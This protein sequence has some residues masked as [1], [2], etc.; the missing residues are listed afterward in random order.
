MPTPRCAGA[1]R[2]L[3]CLRKIHTKVA[4]YASTCAR[5]PPAREEEAL[6]GAKMVGRWPSGAPL[7]LAPE[8][9]DPDAGRRSAPQQRLPVPGDDDRG[10]R[11]PA[12][13]HMPAR[14][15]ARADASSATCGCTASSAAARATARRCP[16][17][18]SKTTAPTGASSESSSGPTSNRQF[19]FVKTQWLNDGNFIGTPARR[20]RSPGTTTGPAAPPSRR[21]RSG[22]A[23]RTCPAS[24]SPE[25]AS[26]A[27]CRACAPCAGSVNSTP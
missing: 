5:T 9:D 4:A 22:A 15:P 10:F 1:Q 2:D 8:H 26:T 6:L 11:C 20:T 14:Q 21:S 7:A 24:S 19:E 12:G 27:S 3:R 13:A 18:C 25:A 16:R 17:A 23:C